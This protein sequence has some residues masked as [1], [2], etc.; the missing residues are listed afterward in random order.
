M[1]QCIMHPDRTGPKRTGVQKLIEFQIF[2]GT[3]QNEVNKV[4]VAKSYY[5][6]Y[7]GVDTSI[8][9]SKRVKGLS[10][11]YYSK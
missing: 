11:Y 7:Y 8:L 10:G 5:C 1:R 9:I 3:V 2:D 6:R 4:L